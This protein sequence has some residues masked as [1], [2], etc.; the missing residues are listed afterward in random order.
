ME[1]LAAFGHVVG[2]QAGTP[3]GPR[4]SLT[5]NDMDGAD[6]P[7]SGQVKWF[8]P[9]KGFGFIVADQGG[10]DILLHANVLRSFGQST[11]ADGSAILVDVARTER[12]IQATAVRSIAP[13]ETPQGAGLADLADL[14]PEMLASRPLEPARVKWFDKGKG[15]GF[16]NVWG[17]TEDVFVH[18]E[19]LRRS[20]F[21]DLAPGEAVGLRAIEGRRGRMAIEV[22]AWDASA[23]R[24]AS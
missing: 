17:S 14:D 9:A 24:A 11:V 3:T 1:T 22:L 2:V 15:F 21:A 13:P 12:G 20:G 10:P 19:V 18:I 4:E 6:P 5:M 8:D 16:A 23:R 7:V